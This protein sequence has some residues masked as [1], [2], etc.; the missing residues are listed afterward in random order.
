MSD[1]SLVGILTNKSLARQ[2]CCQLLL[3]TFKI[4]FCM[5]CKRLIKV[6][7]TCP[8]IQATHVRFSQ[9]SMTYPNLVQVFKDLV[10]LFSGVARFNRRPADSKYNNSLE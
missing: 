6:N 5:R 3:F 9:V 7:D 2:Q 1:S 10:K 8:A 4:N